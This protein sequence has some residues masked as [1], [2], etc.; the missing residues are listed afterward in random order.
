MNRKLCEQDK[1]LNNATP[2]STTDTT[3][4]HSS[5]STPRDPAV[6][7]QLVDIMDSHQPIKQTG[8]RAYFLKILENKEISKLRAMLTSV[9]SPVQ[10]DVIEILQPFERYRYLWANSRDVELSEFLQGAP[11]VMDY[12]LAIRRYEAE[13]QSV[14]NEPELYQ[15][16]PLAVYTDK[17]K[18][19]LLVELDEWKLLYGRACSQYYRR[20]MYD[21]AD[22][23]EKYEKLLSRPIKD[24]DDIRI[25]MKALRVGPVS[26]GISP[27]EASDRL[28][29]FQNRF[30]YLYRRFVTCS[31][32]EELFGLP[33]TEYPELHEIRKELTLLQKLYQL[34][35]SVLNKTAGYYDIAWADVK[36]ESISAELQELQNRCLKLPKALRGYQ[37]YEDL[38][39][40]LADFNELMPLLELMTN[41]SMRPRHWA[42][43]EE[44]TK[45]PFQVDSQG[46]M[47]RNIM[48]APLLKHKEDVEDICVSA[49]KERDIENKLQAIKMDWSAQEFKFVTFK[50]R[51]ELLLRGDHTSELISL[52]EDSL[53]VLSSLL[54]N[55]YNG[56]F[57]K[58]I[59]NTISRISNSKEIIEQ[60]L[61]LQNLW[62]YLEAVFVGGD[63][64]RQLPREAKRFSSVDR[65]WQRIMQRAHETTNVINCCMGDDLLGQLLTHC[66]EQLEMCQK[67]LTGYLEK[68]RLLFPRFFFVSD[69]TLLEILGQASNPQTIQA[70]LL[71]VFDNI[72]T[73][74]F[75][76]KQQDT[77]L[78]CYSR[79]GEVLE[80]ERPIRTEG[81]VEVWLT[82][83]LK[84][85]QHSLHEII[86][87]AYTTIM[88]EEFELLD[89][90]TTYPAQV[91]ILGIQFIWTRDATN[92]LKNSR[93]DRKIMQHTDAS[94]VRM[95]TTL[96][97][98]TTQNLTAVERTK[99]ETLITVHLHQKDIFTAMVK[100]RIR[101]CTDFE[102]LKQTRF[103][104]FEDSDKCLI[105]ITDVNFEYQNE[106]IGCTE[107]LAI[108]PLTDRCYITLAQAL[109]MCMGGS[110][111]GPAGTGKTET[112]KDMGRCLGKYVIVSNCSDQMDFRGLGR[113][114]KGL[115]QSGSWGCF[116]EFNRIQLPV[117]SVAAQQIAI[118]L[119][120]KKERKPQFVFSDGDT[121]D[122]NPEF[123][124]FL[125]MNPGYAGRQELPE[126]L[127]INFRTVAMMVPDRQI[128]IRVKLASSG[129]NDNITL[130]QK[131]YTLYKLCEEQLSKQVH[132]DFGLR[133]IL[134]VLRTLGAVR[135]A[136]V[137]DTEF[138]TVMRV[139]RDMNLSKLVGADEPLFMSLLDDLFP[140][141][142][143]QLEEAINQQLRESRLVSHP[144]WVLKVIQLYET[145]RV[146]HGMM[147]LGPS[148]TGK[149]C[150]IHTL[151]KAMSQCFE[152]H[153]EMRMNPK[154][155]TVAQ[156]FGK[157]DVAT[158]DWTD[159]IFSTLWRRTLKLKKNEHVWLVLDGPVD[160][161][162]IENL[163]SVLDDSKLL[164]LAN[165]DRIPMAPTCKIMF[166]VDNIDNATPATVSRNGM[167]YISTTTLD[168]APLVQGWLM[169]RSKAEADQLLQL[170]TAS[171]PSLYQ[172]ASRHLV[173]KTKTL[174]AF[175]IRQ[176]CDI[177]TGI[178]PERE[179]KE[180]ST[181]ATLQNDEGD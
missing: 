59:Q 32:G 3:G 15:C 94:F 126:N 164:T 99:Y 147:V 5:V 13:M 16:N 84:E 158:N 21:I 133:N 61:V 88:R 155:I 92:A 23:I 45:H 173:F 11:M 104:Y 24:L 103:Y 63:I 107:R 25:A 75:H 73:V 171:F 91:G 106:F 82:V 42:R 52:M 124:I 100:D 128:I 77:I 83:L 64:A 140:G 20:Q 33:V 161:L 98:Q 14:M 145:Q 93:Q 111:A 115:A 78:A 181:Q 151:M 6:P 56:P 163:N 8:Q 43:L 136:N 157:L 90:L 132:Y 9:F 159:G 109:G 65:S 167:V 113:I 168:W 172:Y 76:E 108:T 55:R 86:H 28:I 50:N 35:N 30:D 179:E 120:C 110:P 2:C 175:V 165:G 138:I 41:P 60:W 146:R 95:L 137:N 40:K 53:M 114:F 81:H 105:S 123:G 176:A 174:E 135:R 143:P 37:A 125:T 162:W 7:N 170:F 148:G 19:A 17:L 66:M 160:A 44:V 116:D 89:F 130:A 1:K 102:W 71:S 62:I 129:F 18:T 154:A 10:K 69:P 54:S 180:S 70:H 27:R 121:V 139:L 72:K 153:R 156:M 58:D 119:T 74:K 29:I 112:V 68:K 67:S 131:F 87:A 166:E 80:L 101:S 178:M 46:F 26:S 4:A 150:C 22:Q 144:P 142:Y 97:K 47:L 118:V 38:R 134:S 49:I 51:G 79:E 36:I 96:I 169:S 177:L 117:L 34:Y 141:G 85:A 122:M 12:E 57:R 39:Q 48:E 127:K 152:P 149:T 31:A